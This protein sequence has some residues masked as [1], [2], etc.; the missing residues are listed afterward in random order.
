MEKFFFEVGSEYFN[1]IYIYISQ[2]KMIK[3]I[4]FFNVTPFS[5]VD[6]YER[7]GGAKCLH[8]QGEICQA[9][10]YCSREGRNLNY[11][12]YWMSEKSGTNRNFIYYL[13]FTLHDLLAEMHGVA[14]DSIRSEG[15]REIKYGII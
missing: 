6:I 3:V 14:R 4:V 1:I 5:F 7:I 12:S 8:P 15:T 11:R 2:I 10:Q 13:L 9:T